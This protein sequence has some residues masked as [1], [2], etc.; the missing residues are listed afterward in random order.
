MK[1]EYYFLT[2]FHP[3]YGIRGRGYSIEE[4]IDNAVE[5]F[6]P[7]ILHH[8]DISI[9]KTKNKK[10]IKYIDKTTGRPNTEDFKNECEYVYML[11]EYIS[12][13]FKKYFK[14]LI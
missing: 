2:D 10:L 8:K 1:K 14:L 6:N 5:N 7:S 9:Y 11:H 3:F 13:N 4:A 12:D